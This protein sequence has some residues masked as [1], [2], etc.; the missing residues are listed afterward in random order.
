MSAP[1]HLWSGDWELESSA[2]RDE[3]AAGRGRPQA[4]AEPEPVVGPRHPPAP[5]LRERLQ[6]A[7]RAALVRLKRLPRPN[8]RQIRVAT[9]VAALVLV[10]AGAAVAVSSALSGGSSNPPAAVSNQPEAWLGIDVTA[11]PYGG[12]M[13]TNVVP[14]SPAYWAGMEAGD[15]IMRIN[16]HPVASPS[17]LKDVISGMHPGQRVTV[18]FEGSGTTYNAQIPLRNQ[19]AGTP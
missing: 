12:V 1:R 14:G 17:D 6:A 3:L 8:R 15:V 13:V 2:R 10:C 16:G 5:T 19:P 18:R 9:V 7:L 11:S 4:P